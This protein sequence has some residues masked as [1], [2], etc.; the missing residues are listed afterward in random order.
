MTLIMRTYPC[1]HCQRG[2][3]RDGQACSYCFGTGWVPPTVQQDRE[4][5]RKRY[6]REYGDTAAERDFALDS[7]F[8]FNLYRGVDTEG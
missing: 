4:R 5:N 3:R 8:R 7:T 2:K 1:A 6:A